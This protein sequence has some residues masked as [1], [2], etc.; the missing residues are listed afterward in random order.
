MLGRLE[1]EI[2]ECIDAYTS[3]FKTI[4]G[5]KGLPV[6]ILGKIKGRFDSLVL[7]ECVK[8][9]L[10]K[11]ELSEAEPLDDGKCRCK[12]Q[13]LYT[14]YEA[15]SYKYIGLSAPQHLRSQQLFFY[16][17]TSHVML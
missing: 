1:M 17:L 11:R 5:K 7:E 8:K 9:I 4:F 14:C 6:N 2:E 10:K 3:M 16:D 15:P 13:V 12:V